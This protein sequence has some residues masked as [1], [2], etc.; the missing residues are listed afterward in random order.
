MLYLR[1][2][3]CPS[4]AADSTRIPSG[5]R[6]RVSLTALL[7]QLHISARKVTA[8]PKPILSLAS[9][10]SLSVCEKAMVDGPPALSPWP[11]AV[12]PPDAEGA[13][14]ASLQDTKR[15]W[16]WLQFSSQVWGSRLVSFGDD[17]MGVIM[18]FQIC[19]GMPSTPHVVIPN[20][21]SYSSLSIAWVGLQRP[22]GGEWDGE[23][24]AHTFPELQQMPFQKGRAQ[25]H[26]YWCAHHLDPTASSL[27]PG[28]EEL[29]RG[30]D[31]ALLGKAKGART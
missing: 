30:R 28:S 14:N 2:G 5:I 26:P 7:H 25:A 24:M 9:H 29:Q 11:G 13:R 6:L 17:Y 4:P 3:A 27:S 31:T 8:R 22:T 18:D 16:S 21:R 10:F 1:S 12:P 19:I 20:S 23:I 15:V